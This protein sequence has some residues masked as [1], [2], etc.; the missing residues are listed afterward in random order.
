M[1]KISQ[2]KQFYF[3]EVSFIIRNLSKVTRH[4]VRFL[5]FHSYA[6]HYARH[7][8]S[9]SFINPIN[10]VHRKSA[11]PYWY[12]TFFSLRVP[13]LSQA[14]LKEIDLKSSNVLPLI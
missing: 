6:K 5:P 9:Y 10:F 2:A 1:E 13:L 4:V 11:N 12:Q 8:I 7:E 14:S 3:A